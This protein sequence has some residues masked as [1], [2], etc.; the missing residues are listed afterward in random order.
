M[1]VI[2]ARLK[3]RLEEVRSGQEEEPI[4]RHR[5]TPILRGRVIGR[6]IYVHCPY[7]DIEHIHSWESGNKKA[8]RRWSHCDSRSPLHG[9]SYFIAPYRGSSLLTF[10]DERGDLPF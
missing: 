9:Q 5:D 3:K 7:C 1:N 6:L 8:E 10:F 2:L 4:S